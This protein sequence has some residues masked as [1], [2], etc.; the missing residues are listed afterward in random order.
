[1]KQLAW[2]RKNLVSRTWVK[3]TLTAERNYVGQ[4]GN[5]H[6]WQKQSLRPMCQKVIS[7]LSEQ[8]ECW[9]FNPQD[10]LTNVQFAVEKDTT[11]LFIKMLCECEVEI[12]S[13]LKLRGDQIRFKKGLA[14]S[15]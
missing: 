11:A 3:I 14:A 10:Y 13:P 5:R 6:S 9:M 2:T 1:M 12:Q 4:Y 7:F 8:E 15:S